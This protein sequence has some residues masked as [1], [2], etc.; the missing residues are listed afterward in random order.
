MPGGT[1][2]MGSPA[3]DKAREPDEGPVHEVQLDG[4]WLGKYEVTQGQWVKLM[5][6]N[7]Q[8]EFQKY[9]KSVGVTPWVSLKKGGNYPVELSWVDTQEFIEKLNN[10]GPASHKFRLPTE[11]EWEY[12]ARSGGKAE[13]YAG[14]N[15]VDAV[16]WYEKNSGHTTHP[17]GTKSPNGFG[18]YDMSGNVWEL[19]QD[20][21]NEG[22][23]KKHPRYNPIN[24]NGE[25]H[26]IRGGSNASPSSAVRCTFRGATNI[27]P[28]VYDQGFRLAM[29]P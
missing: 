22:G 28:V 9:Q 12:A 26:I 6:S 27:F 5:G 2:K 24:K 15:N 8:G 23:Y 25:G 19:C 1:F 13:L 16:A 10:L 18:L 17:V 21:A 7:H 4:F 14:G 29:T 11:A 3:S 20:V